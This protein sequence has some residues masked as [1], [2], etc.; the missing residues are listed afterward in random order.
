MQSP[1]YKANL[2]RETVDPTAR[3]VA[4]VSVDVARLATKD[5]LPGA[6]GYLELLNPY[7]GSKD[8]R[9]KKTQDVLWAKSVEWVGVTAQDTVLGAFFR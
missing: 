4:Q 7:E 5:A 9:N 1:L 3:T 6:R 2:K 8:S